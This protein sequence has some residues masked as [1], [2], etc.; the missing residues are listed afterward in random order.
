MVLS[1]FQPI[2]ALAAEG[3]GDTSAL[4]QEAGDSAGGTDENGSEADSA[5]NLSGDTGVVDETAPTETVMSDPHLDSP[6]RFGAAAA[7]PAAFSTMSA[8]TRAGGTIVDA[9][10]LRK[11]WIVYDRYWDNGVGDNGTAW[12]AGSVPASWNASGGINEFG[13]RPYFYVKDAGTGSSG[14]YYNLRD[15]GTYDK[16][17]YLAQSASVRNVS[18]HV[19]STGASASTANIHFTGYYDIESNDFA[20]AEFTTPD[21]KSIAF[22]IDASGVSFHTLHDFGIMVNAG[23]DSGGLFKGYLIQFKGNSFNSYETNGTVNFVKK[24]DGT[25]SQFPGGVD[26]A[27]MHV[28]DTSVMPASTTW[29]STT[30]GQDG[31][32]RGGFYI[33]YDGEYTD[34]RLGT[35]NL[36][37][38]GGVGKFHIE[39]SVEST[40]FTLRVF[41]YRSW[42]AGDYDKD[43]PFINKTVSLPSVTGY[44]NIG[45]YAGYDT[46]GH[47]CP[48]LS[49]VL[50]S[51]I[52]VTEGYSVAFNLNYTGAPNDGEH[53]MIA[54]IAKGGTIATTDGA[55]FPSVPARDGYAFTG[56]NTLADGTGTAFDANTQV[57]API[58]VYAQWKELGVTTSYNP[59]TWTNQD[60]TVSVVVTSPTEPQTVVIKDAS[61]NTI[62]TLTNPVADPSSGTYTYTYTAT[63][64]F[65][66]TVYATVDDGTG[67]GTTTTVD[68]SVVITWIDKTPPTI[69]S[70]ITDKEQ[71]TESAFTSKVTFADNGD[72][73]TTSDASGVDNSSKTL[74]ILDKNGNVVKTIPWSQLSDGSNPFS[75][76]SGKYWYDIS[77][78][79]NA[80]N[81]TYYNSGTSTGP[82]GGE[83]GPSGGDAGGGDDGS[84]IINADGPTITGSMTTGS[85]SNYTPGTATNKNWTNEDVTVD[86]N[87]TSVIDLNDVSENGSSVH[88]GSAP[89]TD[90]TTYTQTGEYTLEVKASNDVGDDTETFTVYIDKDKPTAAIDSNTSVG[91]ALTSI[92]T[93]DQHSGPDDSTREITI[94]DK[95]GNSVY[96]GSESGAKGYLTTLPT[97]EYE[98]I[99]TVEDYAGNVS[100]PVTAGNLY[101]VNPSD[102]TGGITITLVSTT[103]SGDTNTNVVVKYKVTSVLPLETLT[104]DGVA[105][106]GFT[107]GV[108]TYEG[109]LTFTNIAETKKVEA[110]VA[111]NVSNNASFSVN[112]IDKLAPSVTMPNTNTMF[113]STS[114]V[115]TDAAATTQYKQSGVNDSSIVLIA[116]PYENGQP[117]PAK[118]ITVTGTLTSANLKSKL[119]EGMVYDLT[120]D[121]NDNAG[122]PAATATATGVVF[123]EDFGTGTPAAG[124]GIVIWATSE[125][126]SSANSYS[127]TSIYPIVSITETPNSGSAKTV[128]TAA[129]YANGVY[130]YDGAADGEVTVTVVN[131]IGN[132]SE[133]IVGGGTSTTQNGFDP[134]T[135]PS[136]I[137]G[138]ANFKN[139]ISSLKWS[140]GA[141][142]TAI[143]YYYSLTV[144]GA[145]VATTEANLTTMIKARTVYV[146]IAAKNDVGETYYLGSGFTATQTMPAAGFTVIKGN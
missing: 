78:K 89:Y 92:T 54:G 65:T 33:P 63:E 8:G 60:V 83:D 113:D 49:S 126:G 146:V 7:T 80:G 121:F 114:F 40:E 132:R 122:N 124:N 12:T 101:H 123:G 45:V 15:G 62:A 110:T 55:V 30:S 4:S 42:V 120:I 135:I 99:V 51:N 5:A 142:V 74:Y 21:L 94:K 130:K 88:S 143:T 111:G 95:N 32:T 81:I 98:V 59:S 47:T 6:G 87:V 10:D 48:E 23:I 67:A 125:T 57:T 84:V 9:S 16:D 119:T 66:G 104:V 35:F 96:T 93:Q 107:A 26:A 2:V 141:S 127:V 56:W 76:L 71:V 17:T 75:T 44:N 145:P 136:S 138:S 58:T 86:Y 61:G 85:G 38:T 39:L 137:S 134:T 68:D 70:T 46:D 28:G 112:N 73:G 139:A 106:S 22:D 36:A 19:W 108:Y 37:S 90:S 140:D 72:S 144:S 50:Y 69:A 103:P 31:Y 20:L 13:G 41:Q 118:A 82:S 29:H 128:F 91:D 14:T 79:D 97:G 24:Y 18:Q 129:T 102:P 115:F 11:G 105:V 43:N 133:P 52:T 117:N 109:E 1:V 25:D 64:N 131:A 34:A 100:D 116:V 3:D 53:G 27:L 77:V